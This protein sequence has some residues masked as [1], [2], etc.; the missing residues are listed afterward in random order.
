[1]IENTI[2]VNDQ[3]KVRRNSIPFGFLLSI[4]G[5]EKSGEASVSWFARPH[6]YIGDHG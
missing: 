6:W 1:M 5:V 3:C 2:L 4:E